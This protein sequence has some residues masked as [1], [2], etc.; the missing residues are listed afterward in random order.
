MAAAAAIHPGLALG[1][2]VGVDELVDRDVAGHH[3]P[4][5]VLVADAGELALQEREDHEPVRR[6]RPVVEVVD[7]DL[8]DVRGQLLEDEMVGGAVGE[9]RLD[10]E[11]QH[12][13][14][15]EA[16]GVG[17]G[18]GIAQLLARG[19]AAF[20]G[21]DREP[22]GAAGADAVAGA[23]AVLPAYGLHRAGVLRDESVGVLVPVAVGRLRGGV[24]RAAQILAAEG[25]G[26]VDA[27]AGVEQPRCRYCRWSSPF[28]PPVAR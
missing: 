1:D 8:A 28:E 18:G 4:G 10:G 7:R 27:R 3:P 11:G 13:E 24:E 22:D 26:G 17:V 2:A 20:V 23:G 21:L 5:I 15:A 9:P 25:L 12:G 19:D 16:R 14:R 6:R